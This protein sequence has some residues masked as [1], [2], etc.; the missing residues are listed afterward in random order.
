MDPMLG[1][2]IFLEFTLPPSDSTLQYKKCVQLWNNFPCIITLSISRHLSKKKLVYTYKFNC[3][4]LRVAWKK[5]IDVV[6]NII[7]QVLIVWGKEVF[8]LITLISIINKP[9]LVLLRKTTASLV[10]WKVWTLS[11]TTK[12]TSLIRPIWCPLAIT[13]AGTPVAAIAEHIAY[14]R[15]NSKLKN[16]IFSEQINKMVMCKILTQS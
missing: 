11:L 12:G 7:Y 8:F 1:F 3:I 2:D 10:F 15:C 4:K 16:G 14:L 13:R 6:F 9:T 5:V